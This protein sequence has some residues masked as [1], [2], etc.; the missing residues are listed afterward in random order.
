MKQIHHVLQE[1]IRIV[2]KMLHR[3]PPFF[4]EKDYMPLR[5]LH[6]KKRKVRMLQKNWR[7]NDKPQVALLS[8]NKWVSTIRT[9]MKPRRKQEKRLGMAL[10][11][12]PFTFFLERYISKSRIISTSSVEFSDGWIFHESLSW[13]RG[14]N[15]RVSTY[16]LHAKKK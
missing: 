8:R 10:P 5:T 3:L 16:L 1:W 11:V 12:I 14:N 9:K 2:K 13:V 7:N 6:E 15:P 4:S